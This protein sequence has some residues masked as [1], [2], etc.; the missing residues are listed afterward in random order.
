MN[1]S[2]EPTLPRQ[3]KRLYLLASRTLDASL[4][5]YGLAR[6]QWL[7]LSSLSRCGELSQLE[8]RRVLM[9]EPATLTGI[10]DVLVSKGWVE[11]VG[12]ASDKRV[13][14]VRLTPYGEQRLGEIEDPV[15]RLEAAMVE[16]ISP[17]EQARFAR[18]VSR[19]TAN[20]EDNK[21]D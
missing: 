18:T 14:V 21:K 16:G 15:A 20:L 1:T 8:L 11:R 7:V 3:V 5:T 10:V 4:K 17:E 12:D 2:P 9:V 13:R 19:M 6:S